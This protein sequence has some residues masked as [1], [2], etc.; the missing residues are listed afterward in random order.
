MPNSVIFYID[1]SEDFLQD[2]SQ[3]FYIDFSQD[4][5]ES[6]LEYTGKDF[7]DDGQEIP[8]CAFPANG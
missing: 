8:A 5:S 7:T 2:F 6:E 3:D 1:F 4:F